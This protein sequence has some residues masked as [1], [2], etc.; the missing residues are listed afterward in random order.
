MRIITL[1]L[2]NA[3]QELLCESAYVSLA[4][5]GRGDAG[6]GRA[7]DAGQRS[8][9]GLN[10]TYGAD[11][12]GQ[13]ARLVKKSSTLVLDQF[14]NP[15]DGRSKH[16]FFVSHGLHQNHRDSFALAGHDD[17][18]GV[19]VI[20]LKFGARHVTDQVNTLLESQGRNLVFE[21]PAFRPLADDPADKVE[22]LVA[23]RGAGLDEK[24][25]ILD[26]M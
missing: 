5:I 6:R 23:K 17:Q 19:A 10:P 13:R 14:G 2:G 21:S 9:V 4:I 3:G 8:F 25:I 7:L 24:A 26:P 11:E 16:K 12:I 15:G 1:R 22:T 18:V 20:A